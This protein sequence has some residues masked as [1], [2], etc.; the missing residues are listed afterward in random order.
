M[1]TMEQSQVAE[2]HVPRRNVRISAFVLTVQGFLLLVHWFV[3][4]TWTFFRPESNPAI[5]TILRCVTLLLSVSFVT[6]SLLSHRYWNVWVRAFYRLA[7]IW[8]GFLN[9]FFLAAC[10]SWL[11]YAT[12]AAFGLSVARASIAAAAFG[13]GILAGLYALVNARFLR[14]KRISL[15]LPNL[16]ASWKGRVAAVVSDVHL[17][18]VNG[19]EFLRRIVSKIASLRPDVVFLPGDLFDGTHADLEAVAAPW[20]ELSAPFGIYYV[21]GNHEEFS[22]RTKY[23]RAVE[24]SGVHVLNNEKVTLDGLQVVGVH[25]SDSSW[26]DRFR[27]VLEAADI[28]R[29]RASILLAHVP[30]S[31]QIPE[32]AGV[33]LQLSGHTHGGQIFPFTWF[34]HR[35]FREYTHG[36]KPFEKLLVYTS[37]GAGTWGPPMRMGP[38]PEIV[39]IEFQ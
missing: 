10:V 38:D 24:H 22:D 5:A 20:K 12:V 33:S 1:A 2:V 27:S 17:G 4:Q 13:L 30:R 9:F 7:A 39:F 32:K 25:D 19:E 34:T 29:N 6:A 15:K 35:I 8:V 31:L 16:P 14:V 18:H 11:A 21:T 36:L 37:C 23:L 3:Y 26:P 28:D